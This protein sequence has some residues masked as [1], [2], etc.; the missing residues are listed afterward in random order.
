MGA[1]PRRMP[2]EKPVNHD[3]IDTHRLNNERSPAMLLHIQGLTAGLRSG[4]RILNRISLQVQRGVT[5]VV[6]G[7]S[8]AGKSSLLLAILGLLGEDWTI[9]GRVVFQETSLLDSTAAD[10]RRIRGRGIAWVPQASAFAF[11]PNL[12]VGSQIQFA[13]QRAL[14]LGQRE[15]RARG[16]R[17]LDRVV[18]ESAEAWW[19]LRPTELSGGMTKLVLVAL[20]FACEPALVLADEPTVGLDV[21]GQGVFKELLQEEQARRG[22]GA[23]IVTHDIGF[24]VNDEDQLA[25]MDEGQI[26]ETG[27]RRE[28]LRSPQHDLT[29]RLVA[30]ATLPQHTRA[31]PM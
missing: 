13:V 1:N 17:W 10:W 31:K 11:Q 21:R 20:A 3:E 6:L 19:R 12:S 24:R 8:G 28:M 9:D 27:L 7:R 2:N 14:D 5:T 4:P 26:V 18:A 30:A 23:L 29:R 16:L 25:V 22:M 15:A